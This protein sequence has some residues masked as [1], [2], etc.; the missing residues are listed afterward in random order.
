MREG[1][2]IEIITGLYGKG[3]SEQNELVTRI[4]GGAHAA[5]WFEIYFHWYNL[6]HE[7]GHGIVWF[8]AE[9]RPHPVDEE[10]LVNQFA[11]A[12]WRHYGEKS[13]LEA[14][15]DMIAYALQQYERPARESIS[16][17]EYAK[18]NWGQETLH[19]FNNYGW[20]QMSCVADVMQEDIGLQAVLKKMGVPNAAP[21]PQRLLRYE[22]NME[23]PAIIVEDAAAMLRA[24]GVALPDIRISF[25]DDPNRHMCS[26][27]E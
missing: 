8:Y 7:L 3:T 18:E 25:D 26:I 14:L 22:L 27:D 24:W 19:N 5:E 20:F 16:A 9:Q 11:V 12:Y 23:T 10:V 6:I 15:G 17:M 21:Q 13:K 2:G 1:K 4:L